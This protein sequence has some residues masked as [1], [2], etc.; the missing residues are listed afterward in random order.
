MSHVHR[1]NFRA[2]HIR[3]ALFTLVLLVSLILPTLL[4]A[5]VQAR[6]STP[7]PPSPNGLSDPRELESFLDREIGAQLRDDHI[8]GATVS[9]VKDGRLFF[10]KGYG[11]CDW[12]A[13]TPV[14]AQTSLFQ[15]GSVGKLFTATAVLQLAEQGK[16]SA[17]Y[18]QPRPRRCRR[19]SSPTI[20]V[21]PAWPMASRSST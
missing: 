15:I 9:V 20:R 18:K 5:P 17:S 13:G 4:I 2:Q 11:A 10:A 8:P 7:P 3:S 14:S 19:S 1:M 21:C 6:H 12:E 16:Q